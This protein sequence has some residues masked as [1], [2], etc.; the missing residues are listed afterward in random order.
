MVIKAAIVCTKIVPTNELNK[1]SQRP[2]CKEKAAK[3]LPVGNKRVKP[4]T[5]LGELDEKRRVQ[6]IAKSEGVD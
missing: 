3:I 4:I 5:T 6:F 1:D 2:D